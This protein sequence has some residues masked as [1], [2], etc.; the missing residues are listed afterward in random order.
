MGKLRK[1]DEEALFFREKTWSSF[2]KPALQKWEGAKY[3]SGIWP[4][5]CF[6]F[7]WAWVES[8]MSCFAM[9]LSN[10]SKQELSSAREEIRNK[11]E[12]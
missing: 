6:S 10:R 11:F 9:W 8:T 1:Y 5:R 7:H 3:A 4:S 2:W 12:S